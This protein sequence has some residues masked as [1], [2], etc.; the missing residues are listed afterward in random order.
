MLLN[1]AEI[2]CKFLEVFGS[3]WK[4]S[5]IFWNFLEVFGSF[6]KF[7]EV[8]GSF[9]QKLG[10]TSK[11]FQKLPKTFPKTSKNFQKLPIWTAIISTFFLPAGRGNAALFFPA[12]LFSHFVATL[13]NSSPFR[14][15]ASCTA[16]AKS[17]A[18]F[19]LA[20]CLTGEIFN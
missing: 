5:G 16:T 10:K 6:W 20:C 15:L 1:F 11:N 2:F 12:L 3:C 18:S 17:H 4:C 13:T 9:F 7:L 14:D 8:F 19:F